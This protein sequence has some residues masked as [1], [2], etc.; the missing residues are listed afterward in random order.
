M[1]PDAPA[2]FSTTMGWPEAFPERIG[3]DAS[4]RVGDAARRERD[5]EADRAIGILCAGGGDGQGE[6]QCRGK[7]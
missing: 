4:A 7:A 6:K 5:D 3:N 1:L 2:L